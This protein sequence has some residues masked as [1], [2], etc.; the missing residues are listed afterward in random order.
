MWSLEITEKNSFYRL[1][2]ETLQKQFERKVNDYHDL[3][4]QQ[5]ML[6]KDYD[7]LQRELELVKEDLRIQKASNI[8][9]EDLLEEQK[10]STE[11]LKCK[12]AHPP[13]PL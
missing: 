10:Q 6:R 9:L 5:E 2:I 4:M 11:S 1:Q 13:N 12:I 8:E 7:S 3:E